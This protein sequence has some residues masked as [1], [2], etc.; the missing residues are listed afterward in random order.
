MGVA[1]SEGAFPEKF[2][3]SHKDDEAQA[4]S[5]VTKMMKIEFENGTCFRRSFQSTI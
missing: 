3:W 1:V 5:L 2:Y 4:E